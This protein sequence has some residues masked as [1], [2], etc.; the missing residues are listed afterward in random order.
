MPD[1]V[2]ALEVVEA[3]LVGDA[4]GV[5][6]VLDDL[7]R[8]AER[9][10]L[11]IG[12]VLDPIG[13]ILQGAVREVE[14]DAVGVLGLGLDVVQ[15][16]A[17]PTEAVDHLALVALEP[18]LEV[19]VARRVGVGERVAH[20]DAPVAVGGTVQ[21]VARRV[22]AAVLHGLEHARHVA[23]DV[24]RVVAVDDSRDPAHVRRRPR[25]FP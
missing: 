15:P 21:R 22:R 10:D 25:R 14:G 3:V 7:E 5:A 16:R 17:E 18:L 19:E 24:A 20:D 4:L 23:P 12:D 11:R 8:V 13:Q 6:E 1:R 9:E 2:R